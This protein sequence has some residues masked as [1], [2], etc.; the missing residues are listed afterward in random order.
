MSFFTKQYHQPGTPPGTLQVGGAAVDALV[1][2]HWCQ[3]TA[4]GCRQQ[5]LAPDQP[6]PGAL[7]GDEMAWLHLQGPVNTALMQRLRADYGLHPLALEDV[8]NS[9]QRA[10]FDLYDE[11]LFL[12]LLMPQ[13]GDDGELILQQVSLF[14]W[15]N[16]IISFCNGATDPFEQLRERLC[17]TPAK[18]A[19]PTADYLLYL[20]IDLVVDRSFPVLEAYS[21]RLEDLEDQVFEQA[22][23][24]SLRE[25]HVIKRDLMS[26]RRGL[27]PQREILA[28]LSR[29]RVEALS[30]HTRVYL[31]DCHD[32][33]LHIMDML[34]TSREMLLSLHDLYLSRVSNRMN[35]VMRIL[36]VIATIFIPLTFIAGIY[37][38]NFETGPDRPWSMPELAWPYGYPLALGGMLLVALGMV[39][40]FRRKK[41]L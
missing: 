6:W 1:Q 2:A 7:Q 17:Q 22:D 15:G 33:S 30:E 18:A 13:Q 31:R 10:K 24:E 29:G 11:R 5:R 35:E 8:I 37:G 4:V 25:L 32:H 14:F 9:G 27:W 36:T 40:F 16:R 41:W 19:R 34:E 3:F 26:L 20:L 39:M 21:N 38:M 28:E 12:V 23:D